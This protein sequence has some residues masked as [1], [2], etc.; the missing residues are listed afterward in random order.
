MSLKFIVGLGNP[1]ARYERTRHNMGFLVIDELAREL[2]AD[3]W[4]RWMGSSVAKANLAVRQLFLVKPMTYMNLSGEAVQPLL[5][6]YRCGPEDLLVVYDDLDLP[7]GQMR[8]RPSGGAGG[9]RGMQS[10][11]T[12]LGQQPIS[13]GAHRYRAAP[14]S[15][16]GRG[17][18]AADHG[19]RRARVHMM[20]SSSGRRGGQDVG[21]GRHGSGHE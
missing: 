14:P 8:V 4:R 16:D 15:A 18:R 10:I 7:P 2:G 1:G 20:M 17:I 13:S 21:A 11:I 12:M 9:H 5:R 3:G 6:Y 19:T